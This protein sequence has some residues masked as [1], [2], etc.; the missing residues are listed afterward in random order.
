MAPIDEMRHLVDRYANS[1][2]IV[3][4][5]ADNSIK[6]A[7]RRLGVV[8]PPSY[9][10]YVE[11]YGSADVGPEEFFGLT[12]SIGSGPPDVVW[13]TLHERQYGLP[14]SLIV[15]QDRGEDVIFCLDT[16][17]T[18]EDGEA[19]VIAWTSGLPTSHQDRRIVFPTFAALVIARVHRWL[20]RQSDK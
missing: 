5:M 19:P 7:E 1:R 6:A 11:R 4:P 17:Q 10:R 14:H 9:R 18:G 12:N 13:C 16:A 2:D 8:F 20:A 3:G 15:V